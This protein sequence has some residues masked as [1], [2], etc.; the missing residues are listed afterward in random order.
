MMNRHD[1]WYTSHNRAPLQGVGSLQANKQH[2]ST[3]IPGNKQFLIP[4][5]QR[6]YSWGERQCAQL[7]DDVL[8]VSGQP[9]E[10]S[11]FFGPI[12]LAPASVGTAFQKW[13]VVDGQQRIT[14]LTLLLTALRDHVEAVGGLQSAAA[15]VEASYLRNV[16]H[17]GDQVRKLVLRRRDDETLRSRVERTLPP[18]LP[19][20]AIEDVYG[21]FRE[22]LRGLDDWK[23]VEE[24]VAKLVVVEVTVESSDDAQL[25]FESLNSTGVDLSQSDQIRNFVLMGL[26]EPEQTRLYHEHWQRIEEWFGGDRGALDSFARDYVALRTKAR[27]QPRSDGIYFAFKNA[28]EVLKEEDGGVSGAL[29]SM[30]LASRRYAEFAFGRASDPEISNLLGRARRLAEA[31]ALLI[32]ELS[33]LHD[34]GR[35]SRSDFVAC[36][37]LIVS[38]LMRRAACG[39]QTRGYWSIFARL[40]YE[41][42]AEVPRD[43]LEIGMATLPPTYRFPNDAEFGD[44]LR[45]TDLHGRYFCRQ[46][47]DGLE[48]LGHKER[49]PDTSSLTIE[50]V[51][52]QTLSYAWR[53]MLGNNSDEVHAHW[54]HR[55]G[56]LTLTGYNAEYSNSTFQEKRDRPGGFRESAVL[57]NKDVAAETEWTSKQMEDRGRRLADRA[58]RIWPRLRMNEETLHEA[59][60]RKMRRLAEEKPASRVKM[61]EE[62]RRLFEALQPR[63]LDLGTSGEVIE[64]SEN[65]VQVSYHQPECFLEVLPR[66]NYLTLSLPLD[67][68]EVDDIEGA[69]DGTTWKFVVG[70]E[71]PTGVIFHVRSVADIEG[72]LEVIRRSFSSVR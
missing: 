72:A 60:K 48:T 40:A 61:K 9:P 7:W 59:R 56:N 16:H 32:M 69:A 57:L 55:L 43:S 23:P 49:A 28:F 47:L 62:A 50:H 4:V 38:Y 35:L 14:T 70:S 33:G 67:F 66:T 52:P 12:V 46:L 30:T 13:L 17:S 44:A 20:P 24:G 21:F 58:G 64:M 41:L 26:S 22:R 1:I 37:E 27:K 29:E 51:M 25:I 3:V 2:I 10:R 34:A 54:L 31:P 63:V 36:L 8:R 42:D 71:H 39:L 45:D 11:H 15:L 65:A 19:S 18:D 53:R 5:F 6:D 68:N